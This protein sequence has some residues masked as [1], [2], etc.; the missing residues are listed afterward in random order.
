[1][2]CFSDSFLKPILQEKD[3]PAKHKEVME[4][5]SGKK[6]GEQNNKL[7]EIAAE[8]EATEGRRV[9]LIQRRILEGR[10]GWLLC[11]VLRTCYCVKF[12]GLCPVL[13]LQKRLFQG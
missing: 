8:I 1:M 2:F 4:F 6:R 10:R 3:Y 5:S 12:Q 7:K 13:V 11:C 9:E